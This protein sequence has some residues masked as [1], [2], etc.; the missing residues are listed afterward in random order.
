MPEE[1]DERKR[2]ER[3][4]TFKFNFG[5]KKPV[6]TSQGPSGTDD[7]RKRKQV[8]T[9]P[10]L[11]EPLASG[12]KLENIEAEKTGNKKEASDLSKG[13]SSSENPLS[14]LE[15]IEA[16]R[17]STSSKEDETKRGGPPAGGS[18]AGASASGKIQCQN[19]G[20]RYV[21]D[22]NEPFCPVC[23]T[24]NQRFHPKPG[25]I[26]CQCGKTYDVSKK[27]C[28]YCGTTNPRYAL[29]R[30]ETRC[31]QCQT[32][33]DIHERF[34]PNKKCGAYNYAR[35]KKVDL[36]ES[37]TGRI[38]GRV[39]EILMY[40]L[41]GVF[42]IFGL[43]LLGLPQFLY[44]GIVLM[45]LFPFYTYLPS[46]S[47][48]LASRTG[49]A[50]LGGFASGAVVLK[51]FIKLAAF[52]LTVLQFTILPVSKLIPLAISFVYY[53]GLPT[54]YRTSQPSKM[55]EAWL[56]I[57]VG[58]VIAIFF[59]MGFAGTTQGTTLAFMAAAFF[60]T[61]FP[62]QKEEN[63]P[64]VI[65]VELKAYQSVQTGTHLIGAVLFLILMIMALGYSNIPFSFSG[66]NM[67]FYSVFVLSLL[68]GLATGP[69]G[70]PAMGVLMI[71][72]ALFVFSFMFTGVIGEAVFGYWWPQI[73]AFFD[74][75]ITPLI[76]LWQQATTGIGDAWLLIT[77]P[78][79]YYNVMMMRQQ[80]TQSVVKTGGTTL[81]IELLKFDIFTSLTGTL[82]P[83]EDPV[84]GSIEL[85]NK[86][87][88]E[89]NKITLNFVSEWVNTTTVSASA[90]TVQQE[91]CGSL[92]K[93]E[94]STPGVKNSVGSR[95]TC[96]W[97]PD[98]IYP[99]EIKMATFAYAR[100]QWAFASG[101]NLNE[102]E[103]DGNPAGCYDNVNTTYKYGGD[104]LK[105]SVNYSFD[106]NVNVSIPVEVI[107]WNR[108]IQLLAARQITLQELTSQYSGGPV[109]A[110]LWSQKQ[111]I[112]NGESSLFVASVYND[113]VG[114]L[115]QIY[116]FDVKIPKE[117][118]TVEKIAQ[119]FRRTPP[120]GNE[121]DGC[122]NP[123]LSGNYWIIHCQNT[124]GESCVMKSGEFKRVSFFI[125]PSYGAELVDRKTSLIIGLGNY[126]YTQS[127]SQSLSIANFPPH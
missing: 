93:L 28:P 90:G 35:P 92:D 14:D 21:Y 110:T 13:K 97:G 37:I 82:E 114:L 68:G 111:P 124:C 58:V 100:N 55:L 120:S 127:T 81:S 67:I 62:K 83:I 30:N 38:S 65:K 88:F 109:K 7:S 45:V 115:N 71:T 94:C 39:Y 61:S 16:E 122:D 27:K 117:L 5:N 42:C 6:P 3:K 118:G 75:A 72:M 126:E 46:E 79:Q 70:R 57:I 119:S 96:V 33:Y 48:V 36:S 85:Q 66:M 41:A 12:K 56:R 31:P 78:M 80:A 32:I 86:G 105:I 108:Y 23:G 24:A 49:Y 51:S 116:A 50:E 91:E 53:F 76:P 104:I 87:E 89:A 10:G 84:I 52:V 11:S 64:G 25:Q 26:L 63:E 113:G 17:T 106:Y 121:P 2:K 19:W 4:F 29:A 101:G 43:P 69:E 8:P 20:C 125:K 112:R 98:I 18:V 44:L 1:S 95:G 102:C 99:N 22:I 9:L 107:E 40:E 123:V 47:Q 103:L 77:N 34:C 73:Y 74:S 60:C 15:D 54:S 59:L